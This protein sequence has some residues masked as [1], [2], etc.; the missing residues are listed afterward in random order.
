MP[1][2]GMLKPIKT[3]QIKYFR[4]FKIPPSHLET[5]YRSWL[6][7]RSTKV[8]HKRFKTEP[9][10]REKNAKEDLQGGATVGAASDLAAEAGRKVARLAERLT[11]RSVKA[12]DPL[13]LAMKQ[14]AAKAIQVS[15]AEENAEQED[16]EIQYKG[17]AVRPR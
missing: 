13:L 12:K 16:T 15:Q 11:K 8:A 17:L 7:S 9:K 6:T 10:A 2:L 5:F 1:T 4:Y 3:M 14:K